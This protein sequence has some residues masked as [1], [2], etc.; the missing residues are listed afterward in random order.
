MSCSI[1]CA[2]YKI[3][4]T[5]RHPNPRLVPVIFRVRLISYYEGL[6]SAH[7]HTTEFLIESGEG[8]LARNGRPIGRNGLA[9]ESKG[10]ESEGDADELAE[11]LV[12][13][14]DGDIRTPHRVH[15]FLVMQL[16]K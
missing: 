4:F 6:S 8:V 16:D 15:L 13:R 5:T 10:N 3:H 1:P 9:K 14:N 11:G 7:L 2:H 12:W